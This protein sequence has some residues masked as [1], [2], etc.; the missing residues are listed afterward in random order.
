VTAANADASEHFGVEAVAQPNIKTGAGDHF[1]A[2]F[3]FGR[4]IDA[5]LHDSLLLATEVAHHYVRTGESPTM[6]TLSP[7]GASL[8]KQ[9]GGRHERI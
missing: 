3:C 6:N 4:L 8:I 5:S 1:N 9:A 7:V 2:G